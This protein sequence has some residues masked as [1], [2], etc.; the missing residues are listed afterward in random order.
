M[1]C[2]SDGRHGVSAKH[3][4]VHERGVEQLAFRVVVQPLSQ[5][6]AQALRHATHDLAFD[7]RMVQDDPHV[8]DGRVLQ[9]FDHAGLRIDLHFA[10]MT[11]VRK[12]HG[13]RNE[14]GH[15][16]QSGR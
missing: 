5:H 11:A 9:H 14:L 4:I 12:T 10:H 2:H 3:G 1:M 15:V 7:D 8:V 6:L 16:V 13:G